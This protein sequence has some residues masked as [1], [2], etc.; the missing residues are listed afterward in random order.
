MNIYGY[1][2]FCVFTYR[3]I[4]L[5]TSDRISCVFLHGIYVFTQEINIVS[6]DKVVCAVE[7]VTGSDCIL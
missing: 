4:F 1:L 5:L 2:A 7:S 3:Q 6:T